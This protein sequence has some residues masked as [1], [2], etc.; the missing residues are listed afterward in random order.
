MTQSRRH[1]Q[2]RGS[3]RRRTGEEPQAPAGG[4]RAAART[5]S[6]RRGGG[7]ALRIVGWTTGIAVLLG[8]G[9]ATYAYLKLTGNIKSEDL[10]A[11]SADGAGHEKADAFGRT[12][13]N[14][15]MIGSDARTD[16]ADCKLGGACTAATGARADVEMVVHISADRSNATVLSIPR[17]LET[18]LPACT[19]ADNHTSTPGQSMAMINTALNWSPG[20]SV[21][22]V[23]QLTG[24]PI[25]HFMMV[26]FSGVV[27]MS[28]AVGGVGVCV[29]NNVYDPYSHLKLS[30]GHHTL[31]GVAALEFLRTRH[32][33]G[34]GTDTG[35]TLSQHMYLTN[36]INKLKSAG[37]LT[38]PSAMWGLANAATDALTVDNG[39]DSVSKLIGLAND[40]NKVPTKRMTFVTMQTAMDQQP[41]MGGRL[42][43]GSGANTLF[44][45]IADDQSLTTSTGA[46]SQAASA[47]SM[48]TGQIAV[49]VENGTGVGGRAGEVA[50]S[51]L[52]RGFSQRTSSA[53]GT[54]AAITTLTYPAGE[55]AQAK[56]VASALGLPSRALT[57]GAGSQ[58]VLL[59]GSDWPSGDSFP[60]SKAA[61]T[62]A[63]TKTALGGAGAQYGSDTHTC[64]HVSSGP[65]I[66][67]TYAGQ[68]TTAD[69]APYGMTPVKAYAL[70]PG[71]KN[72]AP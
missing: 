57:Q 51:L 65:T 30:D 12:P 14:V 34:D 43:I 42:V 55:Q 32:G 56:A 54:P 50:Q 67:E 53:N 58:L 35:R 31:K 22:A 7:R 49:S 3:S 63:D 38:K 52:D 16:S 8:A 18:G 68:V 62:A 33:F 47:T 72:S 9:G 36:L 10:Y 25:D 19:D 71:V 5:R 13:I 61:P 40:V 37:T 27:K 29:D 45:T 11:G 39:L 64:A 44:R 28:D 26:D 1:G 46:K 48:P 4:G 24:I 23:H 41:G 17:D 2:T 59:I 21:A 20:C 70:S 66:G 69:N 6:R 60:G 15:L